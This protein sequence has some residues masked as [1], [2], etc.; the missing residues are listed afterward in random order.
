[1]IFEYKNEYQDKI[2]KIDNIVNFDLEVLKQNENKH[3]LRTIGDG[4]LTLDGKSLENIKCIPFF[5]ALNSSE[6]VGYNIRNVFIGDSTEFQG[7]HLNAVRDFI[8]A[9][10]DKR[11]LL[12]LSSLGY[13]T[14]YYDDI[15][16]AI[17]IINDYADDD[18]KRIAITNSDIN[19]NFADWVIRP[20]QDETTLKNA[21]RAKLDGIQ[22]EKAKLEVIPASDIKPIAI[23][24]L[25]REWLPM[26]KLT[27][28]AGVGGCGKT[29][30]ALNIASVISNGG[31]FPDGSPCNQQGKVLIY[32][33]EDDPND[34][35]IPRLLA[36]G[37]N[38]KNVFILNGRINE[39]GEREPFNAELDLDSLLAYIQQTR[40]LRLIVIDPIVSLVNGD[41]S[42]NA[43]VR[44]ALE[45]IVSL[46]MKTNIS[47]LG[48]THFSKGGAGSK[49]AHR[50]M[51]AQAFT[52][53][54]RMVWV[55]SKKDGE[56]DGILAIAKTNIATDDKG[57]KYALKGVEVAQGIFSTK[58]EWGEVVKGSSNELIAEYDK[59][60][61]FDNVL[62]EVKFF[63]QS[64]LTDNEKMTAKDI[65]TLSNEQG[66]SKSTVN[67]A[68]IELGIQSKLEQSD[69][70]NKAW[71]W[72]LPTHNR[73]DEPPI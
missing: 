48:I 11:T 38:L 57:V 33:T 27:L 5:N 35:L 32:S 63:L 67:R 3:G 17:Y 60:K 31:F 53:I 58:I 51:G 7:V 52:A 41:T 29:N 23:N 65:Y 20:Q 2:V 72:V 42:D 61:E 44:Q 16:T 8:V 62:D 73:L 13:S 26:G 70:H 46:A 55:A 68:K 15:D 6:V 59:P 1:M 25:W 4:I 56:N 71:Y 34:V 54:S 22:P 66:Y 49:T 43:K 39:H 64:T 12:Y 40:D 24:W 28:L 47:I 37:A 14:V 30:V 9:T 21:I 50:V 36:N 45:P 18:I 10:D 69:K 19:E